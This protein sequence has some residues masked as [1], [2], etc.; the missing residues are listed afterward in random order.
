MTTKFYPLAETPLEKHVAR[1]IDRYQDHGYDTAESM[2]NDLMQHGCISGM[3]GHLIYCHDILS[4]YRKHHKEIDQMYAQAIQDF[5]NNFRLN[6]WDDDDPLARD[7]TNRNFL[8]WFGFEETARKLA[9]KL[10][11]VI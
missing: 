7:A 2:L 10:D 3:V 8:A 6:G 11:I 5:G 4:F 1:W 9:D